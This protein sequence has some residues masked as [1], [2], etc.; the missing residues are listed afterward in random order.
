MNSN[1][2]PYDDDLIK[3]EITDTLDLHTFQPKDVK[4]LVNEY[5]NE[6]LKKNIYS[7]RKIH[8]KGKGILRDIVHNAL[9]KN[10]AVKSYKLGSINSVSRVTKL[11]PTNSLF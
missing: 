5:I 1:H 6:C 11:T 3:L 8:G 9:E 7:V 10:K 2:A 4:S